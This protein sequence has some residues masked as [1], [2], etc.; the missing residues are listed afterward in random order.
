MENPNTFREKFITFS[1]IAG[2]TLAVVII[3]GM[4]YA[5]MVAL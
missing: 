4:G 3:L 5:C 1:K 2:D